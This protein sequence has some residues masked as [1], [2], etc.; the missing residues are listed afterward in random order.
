MRVT[1]LYAALL[2]LLFLYLS[3][4]I[5]VFR[6]GHR[7]DMGSGAH[8]LLNRYIRAHGNFVEYAPLSLVLLALLEQGG[9]PAWLLHVLG[10]G[11]LGGRL[12]HAWSFSVAELRLRS[13]AIGMVLTLTT[14]GV[15]ALLGLVQAIL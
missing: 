11:T 12:A 7:V 6:R 2:V 1:C 5:I 4:R 13:R 10:L 8:V 3:Q 14:L 15:M 9:W